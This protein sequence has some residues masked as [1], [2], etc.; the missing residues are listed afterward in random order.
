MKPRNTSGYDLY[1]W[2]V[3]ITQRQV[4]PQQLYLGNSDSFLC[5]AKEF[6]KQTQ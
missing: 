2:S 5:V 6:C 1:S 4:L 3:T